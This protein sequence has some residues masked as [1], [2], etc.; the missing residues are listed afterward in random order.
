MKFTISSAFV[1][2]VFLASH[3]V[4]VPASSFAVSHSME[5]QAICA[6]ARIQFNYYDTTWGTKLENRDCKSIDGFLAPG[7]YAQGNEGCV[8]LYGQPNLSPQRRRLSRT[9]HLG[10]RARDQVYPAVHRVDETV[11]DRDW[12]GGSSHSW[13]LNV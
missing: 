12:D 3:T 1:S 9:V 4:A 7:I 13:V 6:A 11:L 10:H 5:P 8:L 2:L